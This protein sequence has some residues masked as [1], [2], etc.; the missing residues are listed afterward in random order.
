MERIHMS[1]ENKTNSQRK[2][3]YLIL[4]FQ[5]DSNEDTAK[6]LGDA[7]VLSNESIVVKKKYFAEAFKLIESNEYLNSILNAYAVAIMLEDNLT[8][9]HK[10]SA[11]RDML[12]DDL[13]SGDFIEKWVDIVY[14]ERKK[15]PQ[16]MLDF[17]EIDLRND[18]KLSEE[19]RL[20]FFS[21]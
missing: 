16:D 7:L 4:S 9:P 10:V 18:K 3:D 5:E 6:K 19:F 12:K 15:A 20:S 21:S 13:L 11:V 17:I 1:V 8:I 14:R 2:L